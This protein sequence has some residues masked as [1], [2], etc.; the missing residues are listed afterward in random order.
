MAEPAVRTRVRLCGP[1]MVEIDGRDTMAAVPAGQ[2]RSLLA[3]LLTRPDR[4][5]ER[6]ALIEVVWPSE[7]PKDPQAHLRVILTRLRRALAPATLEGR[8]QLRLALPE[9]VWVDVAAATQAIEAARSDA[10]ERGVGR[11]ARACPGGAGAAAAGPPARPGGRLGAGRAPRARSARAGGARVDRP[12]R[13]GAGR[14]G[15]RRR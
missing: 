5:A 6:A 8:P 15:A 12:R 9:P 4:C 10:S 3:Y 13:A 2:A 14:R 7:V 11:S 1:L